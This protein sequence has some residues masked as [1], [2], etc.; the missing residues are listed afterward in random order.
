MRGSSPPL[1]PFFTACPSYSQRF[2]AKRGERFTPCSQIC[3]KVT[4]CGCTTIHQVF[5]RGVFGCS[6][7][8]CGHAYVLRA[9]SG[10]VV[11]MAACVFDESASRFSPLASGASRTDAEAGLQVGTEQSE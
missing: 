7:I 10:G 5:R 3:L 9:F 1:G 6:T 4:H 2:P 11:S 8:G